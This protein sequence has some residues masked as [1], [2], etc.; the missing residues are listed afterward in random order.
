MRGGIYLFH[1]GASDRQFARDFSA[2]EGFSRG[3]A[4]PPPADMTAKRPKLLF[5]CQTLPFPPDGGVSIRTYNVMRLLARE[6]DITALCFY[7]IGDRLTPED[8]ARSVEG[9]RSL[10]HV[11]AFAIPQEHSRTRLI[12]DHA[13]SLLSRR[14]YTLYAY[15]SSVFLRRLRQL[16]TTEHF[17]LVHMDSM[18]LS[19]YLPVVSAI[20][21]VCVHHNV[22]SSLLSRRA[23]TASWPISAYLGVQAALTRHEERIWCPKVGLN[24]TVSRADA[25]ELERLAPSARFAVVPNGVDTQR[26][27]PRQKAGV[28]ETGVV[29]V[30]GYGWQPNRDAME[31]YCDSVLPRIRSR[32]VAPITTWVGR[33]SEEVQRNYEI[34]WGVRLTGYVDDIRPIVLAAACYVAPLR[35]GGGTR[36]K[37]LD[38]WAMGKAVVS[39]TV[40][41]EGL[42]AVDGK[43]II[44]RDDPEEFA[45]AVV[46]ILSDPAERRAIGQEARRT[47]EDL[48]DWEVIGRSMLPR[49][50]A[51]LP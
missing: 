37:I 27:R 33:A 42:E 29:F 12:W 9:L 22:E 13:R 48:Y 46:R 24:V 49:Y 15:E 18:D 45:K 1:V 43:N 26:F 23:K 21:V 16:L 28:E 38:A 5:L 40:G 14:P 32:G 35:A 51:L 34:Q 41:C 3:P 6:F 19:R 10:A 31:F 2:F 20:P 25:D 44:V 7:R 50:R 11:D 30:G 36:L 17:D 8:V 4:H 39:T 47:A